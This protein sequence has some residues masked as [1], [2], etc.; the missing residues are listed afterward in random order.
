MDTLDRYGLWDS[1]FFKDFKPLA[2]LTGGDRAVAQDLAQSLQSMLGFALLGAVDTYTYRSDS[3]MLST[4]Q[5]Y[6]PGYASEQHHISQATLDE[7]A[8][9]FTTHP[10]NEPQSGTQWPDD[11]GYWTGNGS[12]PR[13]AQHGALSISLYAPAFSNPGPPLTAFRY[14]DY[15]HAYFPQE[16]FDEVVQQ[17]GWTFGRRGNGYVALWSWRPMQ[18][19][20]YTDPGIFTHGLTQPFDLVAP[21]GADDVWFTQVGDSSRFRDFATFRAAVLRGAIS[22]RPRPVANGLAGGFDVSYQSPT[23]GLVSFGT[24]GPL[25]VKG[26]PVAL[27]AGKRYDNPWALADFGASQ[28]TIADTAGSL[29]LDF[30]ASTRVAMSTPKHCDKGKSGQHDRRCNPL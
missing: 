18:W 4:A 22:V 11:D 6:R 15:T 20:T 9:V 12:L 28:I 30:A 7:Q 17:N 29:K 26:A 2:D 5:S 27:D 16:R 19:R 24:T 25:T 13:A 14:L 3:V 21:G 10:K 8:I 23:E 1:D